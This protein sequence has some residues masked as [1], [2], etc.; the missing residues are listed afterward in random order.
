MVA[1]NMLKDEERLLGRYRVHG[2]YLLSVAWSPDGRMLAVG[3]GDQA[4]W[5]LTP[6]GEELFCLA[7]H[8]GAI[9]SL[10]F[11]TDGQRLVSGAADN[12]VRLWDCIS[13]REI[14][15][16]D[17]HQETVK[18]L[19]ISADGS[20]IA[21]CSNDATLRLW[22]LN[23]RLLNRV[24]RG[25]EGKVFAITA[26][27][28]F[29]C[30]ASGSGDKTVRLWDS[31]TGQ[32]RA[33]LRGHHGAV[34]AIVL[35]PKGHVLAS[36]SI[37]CTIRLWNV[38]DGAEIACLQG[39][40][41][42]VN[43]LAF[44]ADGRYLASASSDRTVRVWSIDEQ[45]EL[46]CMEGH[47]DKVWSIAFSPD[48]QRLASVGDDGML[49]L[50]NTTDLLPV[51][52][53]AKPSAI[54]FWITAQLA[55]LCLSAA[56]QSNQD[57]WVPQLPG[58]DAE[59]GLLGV[60]QAE[61]PQ[62]I[63]GGVALSH[64]GRRLY[65]GASSGR[66]QAWDIENGTLLWQ[67]MHHFDAIQELALSTDGEYLASASSDARIGLHASLTGELLTYLYTY[68]CHVV[69]ISFSPDGRHL[70]SAPF[71][72]TIHLWDVVTA[73]KLMGL[74]GHEDRVRCVRFSPDGSLLASGSNDQTLRLWRMPS[75]EPELWS[76]KLESVAFSIAFSLDGQHLAAGLF[77]GTIRLW[78]LERLVEIT[79]IKAH[80]GFVMCLA[81]APDCRRL[82]SGGGGDDNSI[83]IWNLENNT[84]E[85][86]FI[87]QKNQGCRQLV[88]SADGAFMAAGLTNDTTHLYDTRTQGM[89][90]AAALSIS[91]PAPAQVSVPQS[92]DVLPSLW[93]SL[94]QLNIAAPL[95][96]LRD[97]RA[98]LAGDAPE[99]LHTLVSHPGLHALRSLRWPSP[100]RIGL[101]ALL[102][103]G[104]PGRARWQVPENLSSSEI[105]LL[106]Q[107]A[108]QNAYANT[109][110]NSQ[111]NNQ[112]TQQ[113][114]DIP[115]PP[116]GW[117]QQALDKID[118]RML[119]LLCALGPQAVAADPAL[120]LRLLPQLP[121]MQPL[122]Q[123]QRKLLEQALSSLDSGA[124]QGGGSGLDRA[125]FSLRGPLTALLPSQWAYPRELLRWRHADGGLLYRTRRG[126]EPQ[127]LRPL[128]IVLDTS[129]ACWGP[130]E[131][132]TRLTAHALAETLA[133][134]HCP[135][136]FLSTDGRVHAL[137]QR[138][139]RLQLLTQRS[140]HSADIPTV[141][142]QAQRLRRELVSNS[143]DLKPLIVLLSHCWW[144]AEWD[145]RQQVQEGLRALFVQYPAQL[146][147]QPPFASCC[148][149]WAT[150]PHGKLDALAGALEK[151]IAT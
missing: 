132:L 60:L 127:K 53:I 62:R 74:A 148:E 141:L 61:N 108:L 121:L 140:Q 29:A 84:E 75:G 34:W 77:D 149:R 57:Y 3:G 46:I 50:W 72:N 151:I 8:Q 114:I 37:D 117:L 22:N 145:G 48:C 150:V 119:T 7:G 112:T 147:Q 36:G 39:H 31:Q 126:R 86:C 20:Q 5:L 79:Q 4:V 68:S 26:S 144:G 97:L 124:A 102:L 71:N 125:G 63:C 90:R 131:S 120:P 83:R 64:D 128:V 100:S 136:L 143:A 27:A 51:I 96:L 98:L 139:E 28:D 12:T 13:Q 118:N 42:S 58:A 44:T 54:Q 67:N 142:Q 24:L 88:W 73:S 55:S 21:S 2:D 110:Q 1:E 65:K 19:V 103:N 76:E 105:L 59:K 87:L 81:F 95:C 91:Q 93:A 52:G 35:S 146:S 80:N 129:P 70:A 6:S 56:L 18:S 49:C 17:G 135:A 69:S 11:F 116:L 133:E 33:C 106:L 30:I 45:R 92:L 113:P 66:I 32:K 14:R 23:N 122:S 115:P 101:I 111:Q 41:G 38:A 130:I 137:Q 107:D 16:L 25:H 82:A 123:L 89:L 85:K 43:F 99:T 15:C 134:R 9:S 109:R 138:V 78:R 47:K 94:Q 10:A 40:H 104:W